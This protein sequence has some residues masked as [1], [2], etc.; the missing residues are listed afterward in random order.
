MK[1]YH[2]NCTLMGKTG[3]DFPVISRRFATRKVASPA[4]AVLVNLKEFYTKLSMNNFYSE[5]TA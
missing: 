1:Q 3:V 4:Q 2:Q 5:N